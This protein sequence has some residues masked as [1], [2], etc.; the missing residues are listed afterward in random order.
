M[1]AAK[2]QNKKEE[3]I[4]ITELRREH[5]FPSFHSDNTEDLKMYCF[6]LS[7]TSWKQD[8]FVS[9]S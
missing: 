7:R 9:P 2:K 3:E 6:T 1:H 5:A 8:Y 4:T